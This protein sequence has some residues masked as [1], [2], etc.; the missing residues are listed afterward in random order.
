[1]THSCIL[2]V[3]QHI[4]VFSERISIYGFALE[5]ISADI[6]ENITLSCHN[7]DPNNVIKWVKAGRD[8]KTMLHNGDLFL[9]D[10]RRNDSG[11]YICSIAS[12]DK[13]LSKI[14]LDVKSK[15]LSLLI[16]RHTTGSPVLYCS[17]ITVMT[18][19]TVSY[20]HLTLPTIYSV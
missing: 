9:Q 20:T 10:L 8:G 17:E 11:E 1:M 15:L 14:K 6:H 19:K 7:T 13:I 12:E 16:Q 18:A 2:Q 4:F 5:E 3:Y